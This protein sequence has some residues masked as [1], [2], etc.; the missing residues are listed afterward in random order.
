[1]FVIKILRKKIRQKSW[2][3]VEATSTDNWAYGQDL[4]LWIKVSIWYKRKVITELTQIIS[5]KVNQVN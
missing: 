3:F 4:A 1:M 2:N 5:N